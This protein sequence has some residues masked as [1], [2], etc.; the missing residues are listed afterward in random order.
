[1][2]IDLTCPHC[3]AVV[4]ARE[5]DRGETIRCGICWNEVP[6]P[7]AAPAS[8][9]A[10]AAIEPPAGPAPA[11]AT[12]LPTA[13]LLP[14]KPAS[15][16]APQP[17]PRV[18]AAPV[19]AVPVAPLPVSPV[20]D[21][22]PPLR[23]RSTRRDDD[24]DDNADRE[25]HKSPVGVLVLVSL[26]G[27]LIV[28]GLTAGIIILV[29]NAESG[30]SADGSKP[31][32][33]DGY[34]E[35]KQMWDPKNDVGQPA[36]PPANEPIPP[37]NPIPNNP[38]PFVMPPAKEPDWVPVNKA[39]GFKALVPGRTIVRDGSPLMVLPMYIRGKTYQTFPH[40]FAIGVANIRVQIDCIDIPS[41][42]AFDLEKV[43]RN[44]SHLR[45]GPAVPAKLD[46]RDAKEISE[47]GDTGGVETVRGVKVGPRLFVVKCDTLNY[48]NQF[49]KSE[50]YAKKVFDSFKITY[51]E[52]TPAPA[53]KD[54]FGRPV[55]AGE[56]V[57]G[58]PFVPPAVGPATTP[59]VVARPQPFWAAVFLPEKNEM[60]TVGPRLSGHF[61]RG[62]GVLRRYALPGFQLK[63]SYPMPR[64][65]TRAVYDVANST[66][67]CTTLTGS[68][69]DPTIHDNER[70]V[71]FG[72]VEAYDL[73][74]VFKGTASEK[75]DL[76]PAFTVPF[77][78]AKLTGLDLSPD[79][80]WLYTV[81]TT[82]LGSGAKAR[83]KAALVRID[84]S[85]RKVLDPIDLPAPVLGMKL[86]PDG[87]TIYLA[88]IQ[89]SNFGGEI[90]EAGQTGMVDAVDVAGWRVK[91][92]VMMSAQVLDMSLTKD[93][94]RLVCGVLGRNG[95]AV[96]SAASAGGEV[97]AYDPAADGAR[98]AGYALI[99]PN[100]KRIVTAARLSEGVDVY[101][102]TGL[103]RK[104]GLKL[105][106]RGKVAAGTS[107]RTPLGGHFYLSP[108]G[109][110]AAFQVGAVIDVENPTK[111]PE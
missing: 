84:I 64:A 53:A 32:T 58:S 97:V 75:D 94:S 60:L 91:N 10:P 20:R 105:L 72:D 87:Q 29:R 73:G 47:A 51:D 30:D 33:K 49:P 85:Q 92:N 52:K 36:P 26:L 13:K 8:A 59:Y 82:Q 107:A 88:E 23:M 9:P 67:Y 78:N 71:A 99:S 102:V 65:A 5:A 74:P 80:K 96:E 90:L 37:F 25:P 27:L 68:R 2:M 45:S 63:A 50:E 83:W 108:D 4:A 44:M 100:G 28:G 3:K 79:G 41:E 56:L 31:A 62:G 22:A 70:V 106:A 46:G 98:S 81:R 93:G 48:A 6:V 54:A 38:A 89:L 77:S 18:V 24:E 1:M 109:R 7:A 35:P 17:A 61:G 55:P 40:V 21:V 86:S 101:E 43:L 66:L 95:P 11:K 103:T 12:V 14:T 57:P 110:Y 42:Y 16:V 111:K 69:P 39:D 104:D 15:E 76:K 34:V 19:R